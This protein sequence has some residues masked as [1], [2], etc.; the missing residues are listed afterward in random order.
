[1]RIT[2][3]LEAPFKAEYLHIAVAVGGPLETE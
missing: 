3:V 1:M 2:M